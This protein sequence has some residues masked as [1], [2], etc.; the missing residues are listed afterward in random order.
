MNM[1]KNRYYKKLRYMKE[2]DLNEKEKVRGVR[3]Q[4]KAN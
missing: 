3:K 2:D 1:I 4:R